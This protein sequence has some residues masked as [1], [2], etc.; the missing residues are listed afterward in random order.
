[1]LVS[2]GRR[3][4]KLISPYRLPGRLLDVGAAAGFILQGFIDS[5]WQGQGIEP[6]DTMAKLGRQNGLNIATN[7]LE[8]Y[9]NVDQPFDLVS[10]IQVIS[11]FVDPRQAIETAKE[12]IVDDGLILIETWDR[13]SWTARA[14]GKKWHEYSPPSVLHWF[15]RQNLD[16]VMQE[17]GFKNIAHG[18]PT[19]WINL[20]HA[21]SLIRYKMSD[22]AFG[23][24]ASSPL[25][26]CPKSVKF[27]YFFDDVFWALYQKSN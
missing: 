26:L 5:G 16:V 4:A 18:R 20:G 24:I 13:K 10:M 6:N 15:T 19:K 3:Y 17:I 27:P 9:S 25:R 1:M 7:S 23:K 8:N 2:S 22:S 12:M 21:A 14:F 11:H